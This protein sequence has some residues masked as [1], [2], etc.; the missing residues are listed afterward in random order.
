MATEVDK[1]FSGRHQRQM[2]YRIQHFGNQIQPHHHGDMKWHHPDDG[3]G[4]GLRNVG[5]Y[6]SSEC[7]C[8]SEKNFSVCQ[9]CPSVCPH[10]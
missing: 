9:I 3:D 10:R 6:N 7:G 4:F 8:L 2:N 5:F 1:I